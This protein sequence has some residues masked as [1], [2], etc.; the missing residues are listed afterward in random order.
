MAHRRSSGG[1]GG[2]GEGHEGG[3][4]ETGKLLSGADGG[5]GTTR[6]RS[7]V[8]AGGGGAGGQHEQRSVVHAADASASDDAAAAAA[9]RA[10]AVERANSNTSD[11][12]SVELSAAHSVA[13]ILQASMS[14]CVLFF[15]KIY[16]FV[17]V[18][19]GFGCSGAF[20]TVIVQPALTAL[21]LRA[22]WDGPLRATL[23]VPVL[24]LAS[25]VD[26]AST[27]VSYGVGGIWLWVA[28][29]V[30]H[31]SELPIYWIVQDVFGLCMCVLFLEAIKLNS[32]K[33]GAKL[34]VAAFFFDIFFVFVTPLLTPQGDSI[35]VTVATSGGPPKADPS[36]CEKYP[37]DDDCKGGDP[38]PMLLAFPHL[39]NYQGGCAM[40]G[41]G[42]I[43]LPGLLLSF[44]SRYDES[45]RLMGLISGGSDK[46]AS[47][48]SSGK[49]NYFGPVMV[50][51]AAGLFMANSAAYIMQM[52]Q[53]ALLYLVPSCLGTM[54]YLGYRAG[55]L[56]DL[57]EGPRVVR[58]VEKMMCDGKELDGAADIDAGDRQADG[59][60]MKEM[61]MT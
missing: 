55:E 53:P 30:P 3:S 38:L 24:G 2:D 11:E 52:G 29:T 31:P 45:K 35:M 25:A 36:W 40:L 9:V 1:G 32:I 18:L 28:F 39:N 60:E 17:K 15:F 41:L 6:M 14:L 27:L 33:V 59:S 13:F 34:L 61:E 42:D 58:A 20:A 48:C 57:W 19:Y 56:H 26:V 46:V 10:F 12:E 37:F 8:S 4:E 44:A 50:G 23:K 47:N 21:C 7:H 54:V 51:Y 22:N 49:V 43:V 5:G 16:S